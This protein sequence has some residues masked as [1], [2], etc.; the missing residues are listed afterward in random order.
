MKK[1]LFYFFMG[2]LFFKKSC[3]VP[4][5]HTD[6]NLYPLSFP[7]FSGVHIKWQDY[8]N[9]P[10][11]KNPG[12]NF[13]LSSQAKN[14][15]SFPIYSFSIDMDNVTY[16][17]YSSCDFSNLYIPAYSDE[18]KILGY[19]SYKVSLC[20]P[21]DKY[22]EI[23]YRFGFVDQPNSQGKDVTLPNIAL[24]GTC[25]GTDC[26][27]SRY[28]YAADNLTVN[29]KFLPQLEPFKLASFSELLLDIQPDSPEGNN[30]YFASTKEGLYKIKDKESKKLISASQIGSGNFLLNS[31]DPSSS[32][33]YLSFKEGKVMSS[34]LTD[35]SE[36]LNA[37]DDISFNLKDEIVNKVTIVPDSHQL[38][39]STNSGVFTLNEG[40]KTWVESNKIYMPSSDLKFLE[41]TDL[42]G[43]KR[44][45]LFSIGAVVTDKWSD[46]QNDWDG[47]WSFDFRTKASANRIIALYPFSDDY[48]PSGEVSTNLLLGLESGG[49]YWLSYTRDEEGSGALKSVSWEDLGKNSLL[50]NKSIRSL[51]YDAVSQQN[52]YLYASAGNIL[53]YAQ[54]NLTGS[55]EKHPVLSNSWSGFLAFPEDIVNI[56]LTK[57]NILVATDNH[58]YSLPK[59]P[60]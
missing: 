30:V 6:F 54:L 13:K 24:E 29:F 12:C 42:N 3:A 52:G 18:N 38:F 27:N 56:R 43:K 55:P 19:I 36:K 15:T 32:K 16:I 44:L 21:W 7:S 22:P 53:Y 10:V 57:D 20:Y 39:A 37:M 50:S 26:Y 9:W 25:N 41:S 58:F 47:K 31:S 49:V 51:A 1:F 40:E 14:G 59:K 46:N 23:C 48:S 5:V 35:S 17:T 11:E 28:W 2:I 4:I 33:V 45:H 8:P 34:T 60:S